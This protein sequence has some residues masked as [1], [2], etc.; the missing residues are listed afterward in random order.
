MNCFLHV[1]LQ[2]F[3]TPFFVCMDHHKR[4]VVVTIRGTLSLQVKYH[5]D[6]AL[7]IRC[8]DLLYYYVNQL[9]YFLFLFPGH[10]YRFFS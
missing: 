9:H 1:F 4:A 5:I 6:I 2:L 10:P 8:N 3:Q 7:D